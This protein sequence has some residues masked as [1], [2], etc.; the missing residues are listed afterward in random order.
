MGKIK[1]IILLAIILCNI[2]K[3]QGQSDNDLIN[4]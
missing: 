2:C 3:I 1:L 4:L